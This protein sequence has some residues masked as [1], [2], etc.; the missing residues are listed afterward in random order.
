[1]IGNSSPCGNVRS[2][3]DV[4][5]T[6]SSNAVGD[7]APVEVV[8]RKGLGHP[9]TIC[10][11]LAEEFSIA[12]CRHYLEHFGAV[13]HHNVDKV[14]LSGG[15]S[16]PAFGGGEVLAPMQ[17]FLAGR[18]VREFRGEEVPVNDIA[19]E[20]CRAWLDKTIHCLDVERHVEIHGVLH[21][22]SA[23]LVEIFDRTNRDDI[24]LSN[25]TSC[26]VGYAPRSTLE[27]LVR[28]VDRRLHA[29]IMR[30][31]CPWVGEDVKVMGVRHGERIALTVACAQV[32]RYLAN[33]DAYRAAIGEIEQEVREAA[34]T[35]TP[36][37]IEVAVNCG[38]DLAA[39]EVFLTVTG[40][41]AEAG[42]DGTA[43]RGNRIGGLITPHRP[44]TLE[45]AAGKNPIN[46]AGKL[47]NAMAHRISESIVD[48]V[49]GAAAAQCFLVSQIGRRLHDP[50]LAQVVIVPDEGAS[51]ADMQPAITAI[52]R[53]HLD[54]A[55]DLW[56]QFLER[57]VTIY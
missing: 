18:A 31:R 16:R 4:I 21:P 37:W 52:V 1:M 40:T 3:V 39:G 17:I 19:F 41:S 48:K 44:M 42:D 49:P 25:D 53:E 50:L 2:R 51:V 54:S 46:H 22:G 11:A 20:S 57:S 15:E 56:H 13:L 24:P 27:R 55:L 33:L 7:A 9:D 28:V 5:V 35:V 10:D 34:A 29:P 36:R 12:L 26:G 8:E 45:S 47:Y 30:E 32:D 14:L 6:E 43:G 38:D 23:D